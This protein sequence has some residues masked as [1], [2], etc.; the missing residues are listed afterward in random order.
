MPTI[1]NAERRRLI[2]RRGSVGCWELHPC[3]IPPRSFW[4]RPGV[5]HALLVV[6]A[7]LLLLQL[8]D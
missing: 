2:F 1:W 7:L 8:H 5:Q 3:T 4:A 6:V